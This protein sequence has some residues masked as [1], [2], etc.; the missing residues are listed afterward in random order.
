MVSAS[1]ATCSFQWLS[2]LQLITFYHFN[3]IVRSGFFF[4]LRKKSLKISI[5]LIQWVFFSRVQLKCVVLQSLR[6]LCLSWSSIQIINFHKIL[7]KIIIK[8]TLLIHIQMFHLLFISCIAIASCDAMWCDVQQ[9]LT[10]NFRFLSKFLSRF[11][12]N[13]NE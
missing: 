1:H 7:R 13:A 4:F 5:H 8:Q 3:E 9:F 2:Y 11:F 6:L 10:M 12:L